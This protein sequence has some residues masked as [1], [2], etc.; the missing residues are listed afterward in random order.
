MSFK[1]NVCFLGFFRPLG[2][3]TAG[4]TSC[5]EGSSGVVARVEGASMASF[6][7]SSSSLLEET[8]FIQLDRKK[9]RTSKSQNTHKYL[10]CH[11]VKE[12]NTFF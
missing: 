10:R 8:G 11:E 6:C 7:G 5:A 4:S 9:A 12:F 2:A 1:S 3:G